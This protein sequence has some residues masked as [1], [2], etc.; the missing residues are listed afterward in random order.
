MNA[1]S[2]ISA[3]ALR[4]GDPAELGQLTGTVERILPAI[5][6]FR[7][8]DG[9]DE[10]ARRR[11]G[12]LARLDVPLPEA[13]GGI[14][15]VAA[16]LA[17]V[18][19]PNGSR[20]GEPGWSGFITTG[21][22]TA[23]VAAWLAAAAAGSQRYAVQA[24]NTLE[25]VALG[26]VAQLCGIPAGWPGVFSSGGS[27]ANLVALGAARQWA[28]EQR[29]VDVSQDGLPSGVRARIYAS[30]Q[31]HHTI[32]RATAVLGLGRAGTRPVACDARQRI[33]V[34]ALRAAI[35]EDTRD[36]V[37][38]VAVVGTAGT[39]DTGAIDPLGDLSQV[40]R[41]HGAWFHID[42]AYGLIAAASPALRPAFAAVAD[43]DSVIVDP[44]KWLATGVGC[45]VTYVRD[46]GVL[47]RAFAQGA[48]AYLEGSFSGG[49]DEAVTQ[50]DSIGV[51]Y[52]DM[53]V[54]LSA[55]SRGV[56]AWA[57]LRELG[58]AGVAARVDRH[59][60]FARHAAQRAR[61][62][63][64]LELLLE[65]EL[66]VVCFRYAASDPVNAEILLRLRRTTRSTPT[67]TVVAGRL[68]IRPCFINPHTQL[69]DVDTLIDH[70][71]TIGDELTGVQPG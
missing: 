71:I 70:V 64:R 67:S 45:A 56:L 69:T 68:A 66:S 1:I 26:W 32:Q 57:V 28:F 5:E 49:E 31:A 34:A 25:R 42:G 14:A 47:L 35:G 11:P 43:A 22:T 39:T 36:G 60:G 13:G 15:A 59:I 50:F 17:E 10:A 44:H 33:D 38:P 41:E 37:V 9:R 29:G 27:T 30:Q 6:K 61:Q 8:Y 21:P 12:W 63:P 4:E 20:V 58:R 46:A 2:E 55:P 40:A 62:H 18:V 54:E 19:I 16:D 3:A 51:P 52:M 7:R 53:G 48:A 65:P 23:A 24:F